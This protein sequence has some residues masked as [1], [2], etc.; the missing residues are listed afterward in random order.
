MVEKI[1]LKNGIR[2]LLEEIPSVRSV[3]VGIW[4]K[5]GSRYEEKEKNGIS[6]FIEHMLFKG[7]KKRTAK[8]I[9]QAFDRLGGQVNAFT[10]KEYTC[11]YAKVLDIHLDQSLEILTDMLKESQ[12]HPVEMEKEK[13]VILEEIG[14]VEDTPD[15]VIHD[16]IAE[17]TFGDHPLG[18]SILGQP[19]TLQ[20]FSREDIETY[21]SERYRP[22]SMVV[23]I[24]GH[25]DRGVVNKWIEIFASIEGGKRREY[26]TPSYPQYMEERLVRYRPELEQAHL[27]ISLPGL[28]FKDE[29][30]Y[31]MSVLNTILG[32][33]M[34][35]RLF[36]EIREE[37]GLAYNVY[38]YH[39]A[40]QE[41]G[42][43]VIY[44]G[45]RP[46]QLGQ[47]EGMI[48]AILE[49]MGEHGVTEEELSATKE[50]MVGSLMLSLESTSSRMSRNGKN[51]LLLGEHPTLEQMVESY[52]AVTIESVRQVAEQVLRKKMSKVYILPESAEGVQ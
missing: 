26:G 14:M 48:D 33:S 37:K 10:S 13:Q 15:D 18:Y 39:T 31:S 38:S 41:T 4:V 11:F 47:V 7:T 44:V 30:I 20:N 42:L 43:L 46:E 34:S 5:A 52:N 32:G 40:Y 12:F 8:E 19:S 28:S 24:A 21:M 25:F 17:V 27:A 16:L 49:E 29:A 45:T 22:E 51:E 1:Q 3:A 23:S 50:Q 6:H 2:F 36:Q 35:S 9:A